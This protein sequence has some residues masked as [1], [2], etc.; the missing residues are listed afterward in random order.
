LPNVDDPLRLFDEIYDKPWTRFGSYAV[1]MAFGW[2]LFKKNC[3]IAFTKVSLSLITKIDL[4]FRSQ[5]QLIIGW[6]LSTFAILFLIYGFIEINLSRAGGAALSSL[7]H[8]VWSLASG[9]I[10]LACATEN[11]GFVNTFLSSS[12]FF[13][14]S[15]ITYCAY[16]VHWILIQALVLNSES[17]FHVD[18][19]SMVC[20]FLCD[21]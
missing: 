20:N 21:F 14:L 18:Y 1:G 5:T 12:F 15:R 7:S 11:G 19:F 8:I 3:K 6:S 4:V 9:F 10:I 2:I 13:P 16:L 17:P